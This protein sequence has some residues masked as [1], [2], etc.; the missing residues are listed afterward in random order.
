MCDAK[1]KCRQESEIIATQKVFDEE[2]SAWETAATA[3]C[4]AEEAS[5]DLD[6]R[7]RMGLMQ[8]CV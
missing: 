7:L 2:L 8:L 3:R 4:A 1:F 6:D 5:K